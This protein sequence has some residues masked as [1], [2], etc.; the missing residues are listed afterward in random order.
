MAEVQRNKIDLIAYK[1]AYFLIYCLH[2]LAITCDQ[3]PILT[4][5]C[6]SQSR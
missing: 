2:V 4:A 6:F 1:Y 5:V 3:H